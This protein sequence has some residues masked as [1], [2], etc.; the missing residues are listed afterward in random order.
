[1][2]DKPGSRRQLDEL[3]SA[4]YATLRS[5]AKRS[6]GNGRVPQPVSP[7][8][9]VH[10]CYL[11]LMRVEALGNLGLTDFTALAARAIRNVLVD[12]A[13][14]VAALKRG[15]HYRRVTLD[16]SRLSLE[17]DVGLLDLD[18]ALQKLALLDERQSRVVELRF[19]GGLSY[20]EIAHVL[21]CSARTVTKEWAMAK[22]WLHREL[23]A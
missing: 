16:A 4:L 12:R 22:A 18:I 14:E 7:T 13:R 3:V 17:Q 11:R 21:G 8:D 5:I 1:V 6:L 10:D 2:T 20:E 15:G 23:T 19:F 9:L